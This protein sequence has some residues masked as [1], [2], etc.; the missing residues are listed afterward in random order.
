MKKQTLYIIITL[1][2]ALILGGLLL[3][4]YFTDPARNPDPQDTSYVEEGG[5][6]ISRDVATVVSLKVKNPEADFTIVRD[7][8]AEAEDSTDTLHYTFEG[9]ED[10]GVK[11]GTLAAAVSNIAQLDYT[12][13]IGEVPDVNIYGLDGSFTAVATFEDGSTEEVTFGITPGESTGRYV[14][15]KGKVYICAINSLFMT[16]METNL[17]NLSW[18]I[19]PYEDG[20]GNYYNYLNSFS[21]SGTNFEKDIEIVFDSERYDYVMTKPVAAVASTELMESIAQSLAY[22]ETRSVAAV[23]P[24]EA[25]LAE[26]GITDPYCDLNFMLN[27]NAHRIT[28]GGQSSPG[29]RYAC[30]DGDTSVVY[31]LSDV[32]YSSWADTTETKLRDGYVYLKMIYD[33]N[34]ITIE[35]QDKSAVIEITREVNEDLSTEGSI[36]YNY[37]AKLNGKD[38]EY[39]KNVNNFYTE[40]IGI[41]FVN[42]TEL[43]ITGEPVVTVKYGEYDSD[44]ETVLEFYKAKD[45]ESRIV[46]LLDGE[47]SATVRDTSIEDFLTAFDTFLANNK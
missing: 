23:N 22:V 46:A 9:Y 36:T 39:D 35:T 27:G 3:L 6:L 29:F 5:T 19:N 41:P 24:D 40:I 18:T 32:Y 33:V 38:V 10:M 30:I 14:L 15:Y 25:K 44:K 43:E 17:G 42:M 21:I 45:Q 31:T 2:V 1:V 20:D 47:Y 26:L 8:E 4:L 13:E 37:F 12:K 34:K 28:L 7:P 16:G 11:S